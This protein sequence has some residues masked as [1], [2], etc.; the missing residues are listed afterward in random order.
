MLDKLR[1][2]KTLETATKY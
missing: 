2:S 1:H